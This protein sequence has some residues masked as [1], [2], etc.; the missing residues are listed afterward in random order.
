MLIQPFLENAVIH[1]I[2]SIKQ[3]GF[4]HISFNVEDTFLVVKISDNGPGY[5]PLQ[6]QKDHESMAL[7]IISDRLSS[8]RP[9][10]S[11]II[12][13]QSKDHASGTEV[14]VK[15]PFTSFF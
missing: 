5:F 2:S 1:G 11:F 4:I 15:I 10:G 3:Q 9:K 13:N 7:A 12:K 6:K 14:V 8:M